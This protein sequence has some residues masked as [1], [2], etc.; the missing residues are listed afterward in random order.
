VKTKTIKIL[1]ENIKKYLH[2][3]EVGKRFLVRMQ[4]ILPIKKLINKTSLKLKT[5]AFQ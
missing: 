3:L 4:N 2:D 5:S 1:K